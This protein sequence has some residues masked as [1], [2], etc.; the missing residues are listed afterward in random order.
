MQ[1]AQFDFLRRAVEALAVGASL[2]LQAWPMAGFGGL[3]FRVLD[4]GFRVFGL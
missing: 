1:L 2:G 4:L 3:G